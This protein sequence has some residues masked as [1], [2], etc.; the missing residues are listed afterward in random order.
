[1]AK[2]THKSIMNLAN[3]RAQEAL[4]RSGQG[5]ITGG[6]T[7]DQI[8][9]AEMDLQKQELSQKQ[10][11]A[12]LDAINRKRD[13]ESRERLAAMKFAETAM[14]NP[15]SLGVANQVI[16]PDMLQ[17]LEATEAPLGPTPQGTLE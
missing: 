11:D 9:L 5:G 17:R 10:Q 13:R 16:K 12:I 6:G 2:R 1:M 15:G 4:S 14:Q 8:R 3:A 7:Q